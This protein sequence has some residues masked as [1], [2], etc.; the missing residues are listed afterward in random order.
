VSHDAKDLYLD[1]IEQ[2]LTGS[3]FLE[4]EVVDIR[5]RGWERLVA[6]AINRRGYR[7]VRPAPVALRAEGRDCPPTAET[8]IGLKR[9]RN[10]RECVECVLADDI[11]GDLI[12][13]GVWRGGASIYMRAI[14]AAHRVSNR[15]VWLADSFQGLPPPRLPQDEGLNLHTLPELAV[16]QDVVSKNFERYGLLDD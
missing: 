12:E 15:E 10:I 11:P 6:R 1:L 13:A 2:V 14:L 5:P 16:G 7:V 8:M 9:L 3:L 4:Q